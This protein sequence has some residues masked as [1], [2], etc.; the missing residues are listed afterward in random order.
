MIVDGC[1]GPRISGSATGFV[2]SSSAPRP[3]MT[4]PV[5][6]LGLDG[7]RRGRHHPAFRSTHV[8]D[9]DAAADGA[10]RE[11]PLGDDGLSWI[12]EA[13]RWEGIEVT[14]DS[15]SHRR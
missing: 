4:R 3:R 6:A 13:R 11:H 5:T 9:A 2:W 1:N 15:V 12:G 10:A 14:T 8:A 7:E